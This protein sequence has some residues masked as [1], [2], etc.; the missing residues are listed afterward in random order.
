MKDYLNEKNVKTVKENP[1]TITFNTPIPTSVALGD[2]VTLSWEFND[3]EGD[4]ITFDYL[5]KHHHY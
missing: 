3:A 5:Q 1:P 2:S 4:I